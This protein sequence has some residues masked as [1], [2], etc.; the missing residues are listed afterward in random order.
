[1]K[2]I[3]SPDGDRLFSASFDTWVRVWDME[4][5]LVHAFQP[6][7]AIGYPNEVLGIGISPD[8]TMLATIPLDGPVKLWDLKDYELVRKL[9]SSG[10]YPTSDISFSPDG[11]LVACDTAN[12]LF[13]W[14]TSDGTELLGGNP[15]ISSMAMTFSPDGR[16]LAY[17]TKLVYDETTVEHIIVLSSPDGTQKIRTLEIP[18]YIGIVFFSPDSSLLL[19]SDWNETRIWQV[20]DGQLLSIGKSSCP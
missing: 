13:L 17:G 12:G 14:Q 4:G 20:K 18:S 3:F 11:Q 6:P 19:S 8:G 9:G 15:G 1:V 10:G 7:G 2:L 5:N 16:F